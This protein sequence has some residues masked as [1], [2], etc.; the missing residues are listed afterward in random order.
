MLDHGRQEAG[1][2]PTP[3]ELM[4]FVSSDR[5]GDAATRIFRTGVN[6]KAETD[7]TA[8]D[9]ERL[10][11]AELK[12]QAGVGRV[13]VEWAGLNAQDTRRGVRFVAPA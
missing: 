10:G 7:G 9:L 12:G 2:A 5:G 8:T 6:G 11:S 4:S 3:V 1:A 13:V